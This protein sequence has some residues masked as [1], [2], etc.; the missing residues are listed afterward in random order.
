MKVT[1]AA[2]PDVRILEPQVIED[3]RGFIM[4]T[5]QARDLESVG[6]Q[7]GFV[8]ENHCESICGVLRGLHYQI[9]QP[10]GKLIRVL[11]GEIYDAVVDLRKNA[12]TFA[13]WL[14][15]NLKASEHRL[16]W[17]P[18]GFAHGFYVLSDRAVVL[19]KLTDFY[20]PRFEHTLIWNDPDLKITWPLPP[21]Q[22]P[23][24]SAKD[25]AGK[26]WKETEYY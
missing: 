3:P 10:Q 15:I 5:Y 25:A 2:I 9:Q 20:A 1:A 8:Q 14:G 4:E 7:A 19:Y 26:S 11:A 13:H 6:V 21:G 12:P 23:I 18:P 22:S 17:V 16:L 24:L